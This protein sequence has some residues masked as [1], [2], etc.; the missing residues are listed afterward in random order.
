MDSLR[1]LPVDDKSVLNDQQKMALD[2]YVG[3]AP[4]VEP[5]ESDTTVTPKWKSTLYISALFLALLNPI[6]QGFLSKVPRVGDNY[7]SIL[8]LTT[9]IFGVGTACILYFA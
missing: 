1:D 6:T 2:K 3:S 7:I 9:L 8:A 4:P 5:K